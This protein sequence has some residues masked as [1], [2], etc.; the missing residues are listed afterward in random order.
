MAYS[1]LIIGCGAIAGGYDAD[2]PDEA[3]R[4]SHAGAIE[5]EAR[6]GSPNRLELVACVD[7]DD[8]VRKA[9]AKRWNVPR[10]ATDLDALDAKA[11]EFD[12][13]I[14]A[15]PTPFHAE[16]LKAALSLKPRAVICEKP[17]AENLA[18][19]ERIAAAY[20]E[21]GV[22]LGVNY[23]R[24]WTSAFRMIP[25][26]R[27]DYGMFNDLIS[28]VGYYGK[29]IVHN[30]GHMVDAL[31][32]MLGPLALHSVGPARLDHWDDDPSASAI[33]TTEGGAPVHLVAGDAHAFTQFEVILTFPDAEI[34]IRNGGSRWET[35]KVVESGSHA[36]YKVLGEAEWDGE[37]AM[38]F[39][40]QNL[41]ADT[42]RFIAAGIS[43][44]EQRQ[45]A[46]SAIQCT[47][48]EALSAQRLCEEIRVKALENL[49]KDTLE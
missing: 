20:D 9:F 26:M 33:L 48:K 28:A 3:P 16:H 27:E 44:N 2:R 19:A 11:G 36:G 49:K 30:G 10:A 15:S 14:I 41:V 39:A 47:A 29:G 34:A 31:Q 8:A 7:P 42:A 45:G 37:D 46:M 32:M 38:E 23:L 40:M 4:L 17:L 22:P 35:R 1:V 43:L 12:L 13:I 6:H 25:D 5:R 18:E 21:A 24:R